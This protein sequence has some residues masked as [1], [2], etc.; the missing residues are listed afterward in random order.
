[1]RGTKGFRVLS[2]SALCASLTACG[3][4]GSPTAPTS[5]AA[6]AAPPAPVT[7]VVTQGS[8][9]GLAATG[10][11]LAGPFTTSAVGRLD[12]TVDWTFA[13]NDVDLYVLRGSGCTPVQFNA[14]QCDFVALSESLTAKPEKLSLAGLATGT[15]SLLI[16]NWGPDPE[17]LSYQ[18]LLTTGGTAASSRRLSRPSKSGTTEFVVGG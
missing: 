5:V 11:F 14:R 13:K 17:S 18:A 15:Y 8:F 12:V 9:P 4:S 6:P 7:T 2:T 10:G 3:G 16:I 1:M